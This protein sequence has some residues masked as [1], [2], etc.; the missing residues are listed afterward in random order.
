[1]LKKII[2]VLLTIT[3][4]FFIKPSPIF[5]GSKFI[6][7]VN[8][9]RGTD[10]FQLE[11]SDPLNNVKN[12]WELINKRNLTATWLIRPDALFDG[13]TTEF[14]KKL[15][16]DQE[17]GLFLEVTPTWTDKAGV[18]YKQSQSWHFAESVF[19]TGYEVD[20]RRK[21]IEASFEQFKKVFGYY[22]K[23]VGAWWID[24]GSL[25][26]MREKYGIVANMDVADQYT[27]DNYQ[28]WGQYFSTPFYP[29]KSNALVPAS[30]V[31]QKIGVVTIQWASRDPY[32]SYGNGVLDSTYSVQAND[33]ANPKYHNLDLNYFKKLISIYLDGNLTDFGQVTV[34]LE[35]DFSWE[36]YGGEFAKQLDVLVDRKNKGVQVLTM[37]DFAQ[38]YINLHPTSS[39]SHIIYAQDPLGTNRSVVWFQNTRYRVGW[40]VSQGG[41]V[42][43]DLRLYQDSVDEPCL[44]R[45]CKNLNLAMTENRN[46]DAVTYGDLWVIDE[47]RVSDIKIARLPDGV[48]INYINQSGHNR[49]LKFVTNDIKIDENWSRPVSFAILEALEA[50][51]NLSKVEFQFDYQLKDGIINTLKSQVFNLGKFILFGIIFF[52]LPG[53]ALF[54]EIK[55]SPNKVRGLLQFTN[56]NQN[57]KF[58]LSW[59]LG[60]STFTLLSFVIGYLK[61]NWLIVVL[62]IVAVLVIRKQFV[63]PRFHFTKTN[64]AAGILISVGSLSW[65]LTVVKN[66]L[67]FDY[68]LGFW[69]PHGHDAIWHLSLIESLK[70]GLPPQNPIFAGEV[71]KNYHFFY[72]LLLAQTS[73]IIKI[74]ASD[75][76]FRF[77]PILISLLIGVIA[78]YLCKKWFNSNLAAIFCIF[79]IYFGGS[80][81]WVLSYIQRKEFGGETTFWAQ[82]SISTLINPPFAISVL[83][84]LTGLYF[85]R[86]VTEHKNY[87]LSLLLPLIIIWGSLMGFKAYGGV[88]I[89]GS[90]AIVTLFELLRKNFYFLKIFLM[91]TVISALVFLPNNIGS[92][93]LIVFSPFWL[94][95]TMLDFPDRLSW[96]RLSNARLAGF[97]TGNWFKFIVAEVIGLVVFIIGNLGTRIMGILSMKSIIK[98]DPF[99]IFI[100]SFLGL[101]VISSV[102]FI[103][104][105]ANFNTIQFFY[106]FLLL[107]N[108]LAAHSLSLIYTKWGKVGLILISLLVILTLPTTQNTLENYLPNRPPAR[109]SNQELEALKFLKDQPDGTVLNYYYDGK[110]KQRYF[111]P[112]PLFAYETT[113]YVSAISSHPE[114]IADTVNLDILGVDYKGRLQVQKDVFALKEPKLINKLVKENK[115]TYL[116]VPKI[117]GFSPDQASLGIERIFQNNEVDIFKVKY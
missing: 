80:F 105:G 86:K 42:I 112:R 83:I 111:E 114:F 8:P 9:V 28:V 91:V 37:S 72:D 29:S 16:I 47:G 4:S 49:K 103:Q 64:I 104:K 51:K 79:F 14:F 54:S 20:E 87:P 24:A 33:Y 66:G 75:L 44:R 17:I 34:G 59:P 36:E 41:S 1:M 62:P 39:P 73:L 107:F 106:Y 7:I 45:S 117:S 52:Y 101:S 50:S 56:L 63:L 113:G 93:S 11:N 60:I 43:R 22:P 10:F 40:F 81:G 115:I 3:V 26:Y 46:I 23:S 99:R 98:N 90:L 32:N 5:A 78:Y 12:Q 69:G 31:G 74:S 2:L 27:T 13:G 85:F 55:Q 48:E 76:Y 35:N 102:L 108:F 88:L 95:H 82:Q 25:I 77:F 15:P 71:L 61:L 21:L 38:K 94:I 110:L 18:K 100:I 58:F 84:F 53:I 6:T 116:Y 57:E 92:G 30:G 96:L 67:I 19:L 68:G 89:L 109:I 65:L 97:E 70:K